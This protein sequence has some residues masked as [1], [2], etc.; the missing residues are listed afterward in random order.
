M[1]CE[2]REERGRVSVVIKGATVVRSGMRS[3]RAAK[4][5]NVILRN[6]N[7]CDNESMVCI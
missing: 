7:V 5:V 4:L 2:N 1:L 6:I 3:R